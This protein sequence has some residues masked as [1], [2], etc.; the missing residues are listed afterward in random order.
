M[1]NDY[2]P[3]KALLWFML[4]YHAT[5]GV[6]LILSGELT[7]KFASVALG[8]TIEGSAE[9][10]VAGEIL[11]CFLIAFAC[12]LFVISTDPVKYR[13]LLT[14]AIVLI[15]LRVGQ[16]FYFSSKVMEV[17]QV[18]E[19]R[20]WMSTGFVLLLGVLLFLFRQQVG[21]EPARI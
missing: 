8:W 6:L 19:T 12:M 15:V 2:L 18:P 16:R 5:I 13:A 14:V 3:G 7:I 11:G 20:Y 9:L 4:L 1:K 17:F 21:R 10:G